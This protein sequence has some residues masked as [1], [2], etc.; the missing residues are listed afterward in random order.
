V[1][2]APFVELLSSHAGQSADLQ[3][4]RKLAIAMLQDAAAIDK[5]WLAGM[6]RGDLAGEDTLVLAALVCRRAGG[7][8]WQ[9]FRGESQR[10]LGSQPLV[11][12]VVVLINRLDN[13][14]KE[15]F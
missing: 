2:V 14:G 11:G 10:L 12:D 4:A 1:A 3:V 6:V 9:T 7:E 15:G 8:S 5:D 13:A